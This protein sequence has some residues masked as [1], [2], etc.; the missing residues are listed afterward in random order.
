MRRFWREHSLT[1][2]LGVV[3]VAWLAAGTWAT[4]TEFRTN[5]TAGLEQHAP[6][7]SRRFAAYYLMQLAMNFVPEVMGLLLIVLLT[8]WFRE[9]FSAESD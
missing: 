1:I 3:L 4:W 7:R 5:E 2:V 9:R 6:F 8:K